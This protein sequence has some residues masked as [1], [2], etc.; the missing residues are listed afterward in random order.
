MASNPTT[1]K[2]SKG[3]TETTTE[4]KPFSFS[5][6]INRNG[7]D[8]HTPPAPAPVQ[9]PPKSVWR[10][11]FES[12]VVTV[13]MALFGMTF[14][15]QAVKVPTGSMQNTITI[16]D[17]LLVNKFIFAPGA[18]LPFL[19]Q[20]EIKRGDIIVFKYPG[21][22]YE[23]D[24]DQRPDN[25]PILTNYVK[26][27]IG[28]PGDRIKIN[29]VIYPIPSAGIAGLANTSVVVASTPGQNL[30]A[31]TTY[32]IF[33][34]NAGGVITANYIAG[35]SHATSATAGNVG[36]EIYPAADSMT[37]IGMVRTNASSQF[38]DTAANRSVL[39]WF[40]RRNIDARGANTAGAITVSTTAVA[41]TAAANVLFLTWGEEAVALG[42]EGT[43][44]SSVDHGVNGSNIYLDGPGQLPQ[45]VLCNCGGIG[46]FGSNSGSIC[47]TATEGFH[48]ISPMGYVLGGTGS[49]YIACSAMIRG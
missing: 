28:I 35:T 17:H 49:F 41:L 13:V 8:K 10:E 39:S 21:N 47:V 22:K 20:R 38:V 44:S 4:A 48:T 33:A 27:V 42:V 31:S 45:G 19:P 43:S 6:L 40:N 24:R 23:P 1:N 26:R 14:I 34:F 15:V 29:G 32:T 18:S 37:L 5:R 46:A 16:G 7:H 36:T 25:T 3:E 11:Y 2:L 12:A 30:A 9:V